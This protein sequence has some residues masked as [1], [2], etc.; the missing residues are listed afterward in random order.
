MKPADVSLFYAESL[1]ALSFASIQRE[2]FFSLFLVSLSLIS[3]SLLKHYVS[4]SNSHIYVEFCFLCSR[5][6]SIPHFSISSSYFRI[7]LL[8]AKCYYQKDSDFW[9]GSGLVAD[10]NAQTTIFEVAR[11]VSSNFK[12]VS[13]SKAAKQLFESH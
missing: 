6:I 5:D 12:G 1:W 8:T 10:A 13:S 4:S 3:F 2:L 11:L 9:V 7:E